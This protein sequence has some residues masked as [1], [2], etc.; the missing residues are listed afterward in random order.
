VVLNSIT[1]AKA[2][3]KN[4][5]T[6]ENVQSTTQKLVAKANL[7]DLDKF[8]RVTFEKEYEFTPVESMEKALEAVS[9]DQ[10]KLLDVI[11]TGLRRVAL[12]E[13]KA[14]LR[15]DSRVSPKVVGGFINQLKPLYPAKNDSKE[16]KKA[17][18][19]AIYAF[20]RSQEHM[21]ALIKQIAAA[22]ANQ[23]E[24]EDDAPEVE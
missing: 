4:K 5:M 8:E 23:D 21:L 7:F 24:D 18:T 12:S 17:Q 16:A 14:S 10:E 1:L 9:N 20:I 11:N 19:Q 13:A 3:R 2:K 22:T 15:N 6:P